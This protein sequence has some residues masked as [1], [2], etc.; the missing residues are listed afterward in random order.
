MMNPILWVAPVAVLMSA[1][2]T[3][4]DPK[5]YTLGTRAPPE[6]VQSTGP[7]RITI[8]TVTVPDLV[9]RPQIVVRVDATQVD[10]DDFARWADPLDAQITRVLAADLAQ[11]VPDSLVSGRLEWDAQ[12][13]AYRVAVDVL[14]FE[15]APGYMASIAVVWAV[16]PSGSGQPVSG[17]SIVHEPTDGPGYDAL[18][19]AHSR[20]LAKVSSDIAR[21]IHGMRASGLHHSHTAPPQ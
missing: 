11:S 9:D 2:V 15:S 14:S 5:F 20:A 19:E 18:V 17:R 8:D 13:E 12:A 4:P 7:V 21:A 3:S 1:C 10:I 6:R 16:R